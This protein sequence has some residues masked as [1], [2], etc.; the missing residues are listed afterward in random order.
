MAGA[1]E[2]YLSEVALGDEQPRTGGRH[3]HVE[4]RGRHSVVER[5]EDRA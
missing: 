2:P 5:D 4:L 3:E 1:A